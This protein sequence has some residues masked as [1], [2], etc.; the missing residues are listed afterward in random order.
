MAD[1]TEG[2]GD[3]TG[4]LNYE[5]IIGEAGVLTMKLNSYG[6]PM[7]LEAVS[8]AASVA[9]TSNVKMPVS[10]MAMPSVGMPPSIQLPPSAAPARNGLPNG[11]PF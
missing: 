9:S 11:L 7:K 8:D 1:S 10:P 2:L 5:F 4:F 3:F 6:P